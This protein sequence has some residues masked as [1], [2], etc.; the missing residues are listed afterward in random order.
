M[1]RDSS[2]RL[3]ADAAVL[4]NDLGAKG[5]G[6]I[7]AGR[8]RSK[9]HRPHVR[10]SS[11]RGVPVMVAPPTRPRWG[12]KAMILLGSRLVVRRRGGPWQR[13]LPSR[14]AV[15]FDQHVDLLAVADAL[16]DV[17]TV[18][19]LTIALADREPLGEFQHVMNAPPSFLL[20]PRVTISPGFGQRGPAASNFAR[21]VAGLRPPSRR[22]WLQFCSGTT[23][24]V[25]CETTD[26]HG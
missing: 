24:P 6:G 26:A 12:P 3:T 21:A 1:T 14:Q 25:L 20:Q 19:G 8:R 11:A 18:R 16:R 5:R 15:G 9:R 17:R 23:S 10:I 13:R 22:C 7:D 4:R 2:S